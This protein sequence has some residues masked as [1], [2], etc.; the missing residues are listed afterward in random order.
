MFWSWLGV[1]LSSERVAYLF[2]S[3]ELPVPAEL[4]NVIYLRIPKPLEVRQDGAR[5]RGS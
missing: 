3:V 4:D 1:G 5:D 2:V